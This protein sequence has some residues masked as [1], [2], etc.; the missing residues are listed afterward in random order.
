[1][2]QFDL[3]AIICLTR[4]GRSRSQRACFRIRSSSATFSRSLPTAAPSIS[5]FFLST[6]LAR[7]TLLSASRG[8]ASDCASSAFITD[9]VVS[10]ALLPV[11]VVPLQITSPSLANISRRLLMFLAFHK[12][13]ICILQWP[14][15]DHCNQCNWW[16]PITLLLTTLCALSFL[17]ENKL[18]NY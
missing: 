15:P 4:E 17:F 6:S 16:Y 14:L 12:V 1:M 3:L 9:V 11:C 7:S 13:L 5:T 10:R 18:Q 2:K 8:W